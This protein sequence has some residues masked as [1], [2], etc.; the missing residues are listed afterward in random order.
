M[1]M[2]NLRAILIVHKGVNFIWSREANIRQ[3]YQY[4]EF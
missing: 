2:L 4:R 1:D 3:A